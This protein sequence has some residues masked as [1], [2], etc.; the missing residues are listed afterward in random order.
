MNHEEDRLQIQCVTFFRWKYPK[1]IMIHVP[2]GGSR[3]VLEA[4]KL[5]R[6]G[7]TPGCP[8]LAILE[9]KGIYCG[10]FIEMKS[11]KGKLSENQKNMIE[12]LKVKGYFCRV[13][14]SFEDFEQAV[15]EYMGLADHYPRRAA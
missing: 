10:A 4:I 11:K 8:D 9:P 15:T 12:A 2:N 14:Y 5:K 13:C 6:M 7:V 3:H 1:A